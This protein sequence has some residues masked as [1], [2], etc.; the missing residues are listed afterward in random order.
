MGTNELILV[1]A[2]AGI[3][4]QRGDPVAASRKVYAQ[5]TPRYERP[6]LNF[7]DT[8]GT[9]IAKRRPGY[10]REVVG[11]NGLDILTFEDGPWW[12]LLGIDGGV[13]GVSDLGSPAGY[14]YAYLPDL[15]TDTLASATFEHNESG[16]PYESAQVMANSFTLRMDS[17]N[18]NE[19]GWMLDLDLM[20]LNWENT[21]FTAALPDRSTEVVKARGTKVYIDDEGDAWGDTQLLGSLISASVTV[22]NNLH[23]KAFAE[24]EKTAAPGRVG[25]GELTLDAQFTVEFDNDDEFANYRSDDPVMRK[26]RL[27]REGS[28]IHDAVTKLFQIDMAGYWSSWSRG[29]RNGNLTATF[30][31]TGYFDIDS[32]MMF[33]VNF[34]NGLS[35]LA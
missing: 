7:Q 19:P 34:V 26:I 3:E 21:T 30:A 4:S 8:S 18:N 1:K 9:F 25:K 28:V 22:T 29:D 11:F 31:L 20:A 5:L 14:E 10:G 24:D 12:M 13:S 17:D 33:G 6:L 16:N 23:Y 15:T 2:Q 32:Q 27:E 35:A